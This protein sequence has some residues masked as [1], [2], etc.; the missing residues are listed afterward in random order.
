MCTCTRSFTHAGAYTHEVF[1]CGC[2]LLVLH[3]MYILLLCFSATNTCSGF[4]KGSF[5]QDWAP[6][7]M[8]SRVK[9]GGPDFG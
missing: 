8:V 4:S 6:D 9:Y 3:S 1:T 2:F 5:L 7:Y